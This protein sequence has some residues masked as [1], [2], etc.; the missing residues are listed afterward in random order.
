MT[1]YTPP[2]SHVWFG[3]AETCPACGAILPSEPEDLKHPS[4]DHYGYAFKA[5]KERVTP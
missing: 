5:P 3:L 1:D 2:T 4:C